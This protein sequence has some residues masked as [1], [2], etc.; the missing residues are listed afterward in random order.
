MSERTYI[1]YDG[2]AAGGDTS[3]ASVLCVHSRP[4]LAWEDRKDYGAHTVCYSYAQECGQLIDE[5]FEFAWKQSRRYRR[6][7]NYRRN[8]AAR[9]AAERA[10]A[11]VEEKQ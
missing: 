4:Y 10:L 8:R 2:R 3:E 9:K 7:K 11:A 1:L 5:R 6:S